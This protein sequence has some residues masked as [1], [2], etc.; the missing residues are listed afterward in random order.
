MSEETFDRIAT[1]YDEALPAH[2]VAH[3]LDK[4]TEFVA[5]CARPAAGSTSAAGPGV[6]AARLAARGY[7][8]TGH[9]SRRPGCST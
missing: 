3:Y 8:M 1:D 6:L 5:A 9:R 2:V 7:E 4:R